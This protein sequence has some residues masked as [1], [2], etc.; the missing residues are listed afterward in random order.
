MTVQD[1]P[2]ILVEVLRRLVTLS[3]TALADVIVT[4]ADRHCPAGLCDCLLTAYPGLTFALVIGDDGETVHLG[5]R[6]GHMLLLRPGPVSLRSPWLR[7]LALDLYA[8][9]VRWARR[10]TGNV[11]QRNSL[12]AGQ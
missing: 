6:D 7:A 11:A 1:R 12:G 3:R 4:T 2:V 8:E 5:S 10:P 9:R